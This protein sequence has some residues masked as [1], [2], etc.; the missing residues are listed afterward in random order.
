MGWGYRAACCAW[1]PAGPLGSR[2]DCGLEVGAGGLGLSHQQIGGTQVEV[3]GGKAMIQM[4]RPH[5]EPFGAGQITLADQNL[6]HKVQVD[7][8]P[9]DLRPSAGGQAAGRPAQPGNG[10]QGKNG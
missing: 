6:A 10:N 7:R 2:A 5:Q 4:H 9:R 3:C 1:L 8:G